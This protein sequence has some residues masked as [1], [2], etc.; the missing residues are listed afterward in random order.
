MAPRLLLFDAVFMLS[1]TR[2]SLSLKLAPRP[3]IAVWSIG[4]SGLEGSSTRTSG[5]GTKTGTR[6]FS[7]G[8]SGASRRLVPLVVDI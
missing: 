8:R 3:M 1:K 2:E 5:T 4:L 7:F 6:M